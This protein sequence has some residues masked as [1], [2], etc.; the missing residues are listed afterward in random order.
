[1]FTYDT[2]SQLFIPT[3]RSKHVLNM[4]CS[5]FLEQKRCDVGKLSKYYFFLSV[6]C[7]HHK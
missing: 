6:L 1:M 5:E 3:L 7:A 4:L 2:Y